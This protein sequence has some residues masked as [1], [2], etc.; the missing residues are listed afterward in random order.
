M[1]KAFRL[2]TFGLLG[3]KAACVI[4]HQ[5]RNLPTL[6]VLTAFSLNR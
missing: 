1:G 6:F 2:K 3:Q 5:L 4:D